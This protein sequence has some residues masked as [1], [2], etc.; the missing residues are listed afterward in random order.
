MWF[1]GDEGCDMTRYFGFGF[2]RDSSWRGVA[3]VAGG[4]GQKCA[5]FQPNKN[6]LVT[7]A[8]LANVSG[9]GGGFLGCS[10]R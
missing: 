1:T 6:G 8:G 3:V 5:G 7:G 4:G 2:Q 9:C 10:K